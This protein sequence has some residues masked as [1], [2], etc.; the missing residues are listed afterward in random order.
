LLE[1]DTGRMIVARL[2]EGEDLFDAIKRRAEEAGIKAGC[3]SA[4]GTL[5]KARI[6]YY[7]DGKYEHKVFSGPLEIASCI[8]NI[9]LDEE[10]KVVVHAHIVLS[11]EQFRAFGGHLTE[12]SIV[13]ATAELVIVE[14]TG[15]GL[16][17]SFDETTGLKLLNLG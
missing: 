10:G 13:G 6:G 15:F 14:G 12:Q 8:G 2:L 1:G 3:F 16:R 11:D 7:R 5:S 4:I 9:A 17:R